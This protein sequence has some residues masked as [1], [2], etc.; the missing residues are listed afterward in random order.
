MEL[1]PETLDEIRQTDPIVC[2]Y[3]ADEGGAPNPV[4]Q[5]IDRWST[6]QD[7]G[8][9]VRCSAGHEFLHAFVSI[10]GCLYFGSVTVKR[11]A[12]TRR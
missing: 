5:V 10:D 8:Q 12:S 3:C 7:T 2:S 1:P 11:A 4:L 6:E 9:V